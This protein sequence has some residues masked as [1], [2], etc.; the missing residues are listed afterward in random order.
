[1]NEKTSKLIRRY[2]MAKGGDLKQAKKALKREWVSLSGKERY[3]KRQ[4]M[5]KELKGE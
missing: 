3:F 5:L 1:M 2:A 4:E